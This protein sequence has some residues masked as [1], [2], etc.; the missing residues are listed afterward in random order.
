MGLSKL[1]EACQRIFE[2]PELLP[3]IDNIPFESTELLPYDEYQTSD[4]DSLS[5]T[6]HEQPDER[7]VPPKLPPRVSRASAAR[8]VNHHTLPSVVLAAASGCHLCNLFLRHL[9]IG[10]ELHEWAHQEHRTLMEE[11]SPLVNG[12]VMINRPSAE[13]PSDELS[14][15]LSFYMIK[16]GAP[17]HVYTSISLNMYPTSSRQTRNGRYDMIVL[18]ES[19]VFRRYA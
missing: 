3:E 9:Q 14:L 4:D 5:T 13:E 1:C 8:I 17:I 7:D 2:G 16:G 19:M 10:T 15:K 18:T 11:R 12:L 6:D